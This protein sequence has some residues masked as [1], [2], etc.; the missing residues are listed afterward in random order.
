MSRALIYA[1]SGYMAIDMAATAPGHYAIF[2][3]ICGAILLVAALFVVH[4]EAR[5]RRR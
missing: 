5:A 1:A 2:M 4:D 3:R